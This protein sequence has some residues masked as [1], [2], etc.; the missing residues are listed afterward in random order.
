MAE[1]FKAADCKSASENFAGSNPAPPIISLF[2][3]VL[4]FALRLIL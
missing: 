4:G 2:K 1:W 3:P